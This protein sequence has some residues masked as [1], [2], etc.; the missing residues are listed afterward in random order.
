[1]PRSSGRFQDST[2]GVSHDALDVVRSGPKSG[3]NV[4]TAIV[5]ARWAPLPVVWTAIVVARPSSTREGHG[6]TAP[7]ETE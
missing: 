1:M 4:S 6:A 5:S 3:A 7:T 2:S